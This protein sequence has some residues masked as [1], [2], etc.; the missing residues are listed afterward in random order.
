MAFIV[1]RNFV[2]YIYV[3]SSTSS[4]TM[5]SW[6]HV[7]LKWSKFLERKRSGFF[8]FFILSTSMTSTYDKLML[9]FEDF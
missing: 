8:K 1:Q 6:F 3:V 5:I 4:V 2:L 9:S 7:E